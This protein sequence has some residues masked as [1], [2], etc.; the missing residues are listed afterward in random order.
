MAIEKF[1]LMNSAF[2]IVSSVEEAAMSSDLLRGLIFK[3]EDLREH[4]I[5]IDK[6]ARAFSKDLKA[7]SRTGSSHE[8][9]MMVRNAWAEIESLLRRFGR[10]I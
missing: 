1:G 8:N 9:D 3:N 7:Y 6:S 10:N 4:K 5:D 2:A